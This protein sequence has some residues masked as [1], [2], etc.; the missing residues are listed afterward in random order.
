VRWCKQGLV[1]AISPMNYST[2]TAVVERRLRDTQRLLEHVPIEIIEGLGRKSSAGENTPTDFARQVRGVL[3]M[4][5]QGV[6]IFHL[7]ALTDQ[8]LELLGGL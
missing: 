6:A 7:D 2:D 5:A 1:D 4:R 8:D 3:E